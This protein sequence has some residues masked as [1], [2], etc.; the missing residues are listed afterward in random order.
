MLLD[1]YQHIL[2]FPQGDIYK[3]PAQNLL[4]HLPLLA[5]ADEVVYFQD[6]ARL[7]RGNHLV[8][9][10]GG[11]AVHREPVDKARNPGT[12]LANGGLSRWVHCG[13]RGHL[14]VAGCGLGEWLEAGPD[15]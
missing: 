3:P 1:F 7:Y 9:G 2:Y 15:L 13:A 6:A 4:R 5:I 11:P 14:H 10:S 12:P 8:D